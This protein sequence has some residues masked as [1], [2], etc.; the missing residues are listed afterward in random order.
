MTLPFSLFVCFKVRNA[1]KNVY[2][3]G[4]LI[5]WFMNTWLEA[6]FFKK[7]SSIMKKEVVMNNIFINL[8]LYY[9]IIE[10]L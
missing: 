8:L 6:F 7:K 5:A 2:F 9:I 3:Y 1:L 4:P 10:K